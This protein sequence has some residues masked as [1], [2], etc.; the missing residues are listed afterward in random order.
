M[1]VKCPKC[2]SSNVCEILCGMPT[3]EAFELEKQGKLILGGC[4][5][6][7]DLPQPDYGCL[8][9]KFEWAPELLLASNIV[10]IRFKIWTSMEMDGDLQKYTVYELLP[11]GMVRI[12]CY[13]GKSRKSIDKQIR[14]IKKSDMQKLSVALQKELNVPFFAREDNRSEKHFDLQISYVDGRKVV[15][16][17]SDEGADVFLRLLDNIVG[18]YIENREN[19]SKLN[20]EK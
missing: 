16:K 5:V 9:C 6:M 19:D 18:L 10:K 12:Y 4:L 14:H 1:K 20:T 7:D 8:D 17:S 15:V 3:G 13:E 2:G 11:D